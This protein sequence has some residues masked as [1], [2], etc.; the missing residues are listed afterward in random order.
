MVAVATDPLL[1]TAEVARALSV[2]PRTVVRLVASG[3]MPGVRIGGQIR[4]S[5]TELAKYLEDNRG[6]AA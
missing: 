1:R 5:R 4:V 3:Q 6:R 2:S